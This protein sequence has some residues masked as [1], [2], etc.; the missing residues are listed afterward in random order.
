M[1]DLRSFTLFGRNARNEDQVLS[2]LKKILIFQVTFLM[3][4]TCPSRR[5]L[6]RQKSII[7]SSKDLIAMLPIKTFLAKFNKTFSRLELFRNKQMSKVMF[8]AGIE[9]DID[10]EMT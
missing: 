3:L 2:V 10:I 6:G 5:K 7:Y 4:I 1:M 9:I 8:V